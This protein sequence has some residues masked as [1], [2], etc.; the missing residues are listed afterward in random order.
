MWI[1]CVNSAT[2]SLYNEEL[3]D[4]PVVFGR[5][6]T[7]QVPKDVGEALVEE[8]DVIRPKSSSSNDSEETDSGSD[9]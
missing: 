6:G 5:S 2:E 9:N 3:M 4:E 8:Y 7:A 1:E